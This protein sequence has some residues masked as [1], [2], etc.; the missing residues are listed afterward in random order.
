MK[1]VL[2]VGASGM[3]GRAVAKALDEN[4]EVIK[5]NHT[6][7][8]DVLV[9]LESNDSIRSMFD[10]VGEVDAVISTA[11]N[12]IFSPYQ[13]LTDADYNSMLQNKLMGQ[14][15]LLRLGQKHL[16]ANGSVTLTSG[17]ASRQPMPGTAGISMVTAALESFVSA[18]SLEL[19]TIRVNVVS[20]AM[21]K[22]S[23]EL[24]GFN[25]SH[26][27]SAAD[28]AKAYVASLE[29]EMHGQTLDTPDYV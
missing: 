22:E 14:V 15:N 16:K 29:G 26:G 3:L 17:L 24:F 27:I 13:K 12:G 28:T 23:M 9:D 21:V 8:A 10:Q 20:P 4:Y 5:A 2:L 19:D 7:K 1:K 11:G 18:A 25:G 6:T